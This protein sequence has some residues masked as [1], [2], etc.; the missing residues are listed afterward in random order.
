[1]GDGDPGRDLRGVRAVVPARHRW[2]NRPSA[3]DQALAVL[4]PRAANRCHLAT[5]EKNY[6]RL[7]TSGQNPRTSPV[8]CVTQRRED[9]DGAAFLSV[10]RPRARGIESVRAYLLRAERSGLVRMM[11]RTLGAGRA[12]WAR[13][14]FGC[15]S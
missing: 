11:L 12:C 9:A 1:M 7:S 13:P 10:S 14:R 8:A 15:R 6:G 3:A 5:V 4:P 2:R